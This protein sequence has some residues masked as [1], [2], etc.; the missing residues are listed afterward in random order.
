MSKY[1]LCDC[2]RRTTTVPCSYCRQG[3]SPPRPDVKTLPL[4]YLV[5]CATELQRRRDEINAVL[6]KLGR[7]A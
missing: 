7:V 1:A 4:E 6:S 3:R 2:G 5:S